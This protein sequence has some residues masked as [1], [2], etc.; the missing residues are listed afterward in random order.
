VNETPTTY[1]E[2]LQT[3]HWQRRRTATLERDGYT[4]QHCGA[5]DTELHVHHLVYRGWYNELASDLITLC[6]DCHEKEHDM[7]RARLHWTW[8]VFA[9]VLLT[10]VIGAVFGL[11]A[12]LL[13]NVAPLVIGALLN[14]VLEG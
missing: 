14:M 6:A 3:D 9:W 5:T 2:Y 1:T 11:G 12:A 13:W 7:E 8:A 4:C 10:L